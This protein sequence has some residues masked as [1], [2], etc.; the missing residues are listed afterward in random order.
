MYIKV[1]H[2][3]KKVGNFAYT[4]FAILSASSNFFKDMMYACEYDIRDSADY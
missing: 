4:A 3:W 1:C 2:T